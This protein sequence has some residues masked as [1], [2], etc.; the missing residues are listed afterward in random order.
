MKYNYVWSTEKKT[1]KQF[2]FEIIKKSTII[3]VYNSKGCFKKNLMLD[4]ILFCDCSV[5]YKIHYL[6]RAKVYNK[7]T[8]SF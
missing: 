6:F 5:Y 8:K 1:L 2:N 7:E 3:N 4:F